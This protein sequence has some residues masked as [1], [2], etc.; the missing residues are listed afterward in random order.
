MLALL[1]S[2]I[3]RAVQAQRIDVQ[4]AAGARVETR[5]GKVVTVSMRVSNNSTSSVRFEPSVVL[6]KGWRAFKKESSFELSAGASDI[7]LISFSLPAETPPGRYEV[8]YGVKDAADPTITAQALVSVVVT[9]VQ[10]L[11]LRL[12]ELPRYVV[13]G[14][15]Y[16]AFFLVTNKGNAASG[17]RLLPRSSSNFPVQ[18]DSS[19]V[20]LRPNETRQMRV[21]VQTDPEATQKVQDVLEIIAKSDR[22]SLVTAR[23]SGSVEVVPKVTGTEDRFFEFPLEVR[24]RA[25]GERTTRGAQVEIM[26]SGA[27]GE[28]RRDRLDVLLR[29]P[30]IQQRSILGQRD[31]YRVSYQSDGYELYAGDKN[32]S[33]T[34][35]TEFNRYAFGAGGKATFSRVTLGGFYNETRFLVPIQKERGGFLSYQLGE[36]TELG[37]NYL[38]KIDQDESDIVTLRG[39]L[40][41]LE[42]SEV[43]LEYGR[44]YRGS[45]VDKAYAARVEGREQWIAYEARYVWAGPKYGGYY[46]DVEFKTL[47][48]NVMPWGNLRL[49]AY[50]RDEERNLKRD[51]TLFFSPRER[52]YQVGVGYSD[53]FAVY[54]RVNHQDDLSPIPKYRRDEEMAQVR[55]GYNFPF[56]GLIANADVGTTR[57]TLVGKKYPFQRYTLFTSFR[58]TASSSIGLSVEYSKDQNIFTDEIQKRLSGGL[59]AWLMLG[60]TTQF[61]LSAYGNRMPDSIKQ[62]YYLVDVALEHTFP[63]GHKLALRGRQSEFT[64]S[65]TPK[66]VAY[67][68]EYSI[69][70]NVPLSRITAIGQLRGRVVDAEAGT[71]LQNV[72]IY[73]GGGTAVTD[74]EGEFFFPSLKPENCYV[75][76]D[77][78]SI[79]LNRV[80]SQPMPREI[81]IKGGEEAR[82][83][84]GVIRGAAISGTVLIYGTKDTVL[85]DTSRAP[86]VELGGHPNVVLELANP[87]ESHRRISD[88][89]GRFSFTGIRPGRWTLRVIEGNLPVNHNFER[90]SLDL[91][92]SPGGTQQVTL[93]IL[94]RRRRIQILQEGKLLVETKPTPEKKPAI[95]QPAASAFRERRD[96][97]LSYDAALRIYESGKYQKAIE[98][99]QELLRRGIDRD[100]QDN[101]RLWIGVSYFNLKRFDRA[102][103][104][105]KQVIGWRGTD[106]KADA[107]FMLGQT[108]EQLGNRQQAK[109]MF[110]ALLKE[111]PSGELAPVARRKLERLGSMK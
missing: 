7:R 97:L 11:E 88:N 76:I 25:A 47:N 6:P 3:A 10:Q 29:T 102:A 103:S 23:A 108:Y 85:A 61:T 111:F 21:V 41:P 44:G 59:S 106:K 78:S 96:S 63:F 27:L 33:L 15:R 2:A 17:I 51:T 90:E 64:P 22:D 67:L 42:N 56:L 62:T 37:L 54:Y 86:L 100:L 1:A 72:L 82:L 69:P 77:M 45:V 24:L 66:D 74:R 8:R 35:L 53:L 83:D 48:L 38:R 92:V 16:A 39:L 81:T 79:G 9:F 40:R 73:A 91:E 93:K 94:P 70:I 20:Q 5:P 28:G 99:L 58:P 43:E 32:Y 14:D 52:Y 26:G 46:R 30:D 55:L 104:K 68:L 65:V 34:P 101:C 60:A 13:A 109:T 95:R 36:R 18:V 80:P 71:G 50:Y 12:L 49:E 84:L 57:D 31:E 89:R 107:L 4:P 87:V 19:R 105:F 110:E 98:A 75:Q